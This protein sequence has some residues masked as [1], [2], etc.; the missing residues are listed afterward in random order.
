MDAAS[1]RGIDDIREIRRTRRA[2]AGRGPLQDL[3][4]R[5]G[6]LADRRR[7]E[8]AAE[9]ARGAASARR[10]RALH[11]RSGQAAEHDPLALPALRVPAARAGR[12][13]EG[14]HARVRGRGDRGARG[15]AAPDRPRGCG[16]LPRRAD[17]PRPARR[18]SATARSPSRT[19]CACSASCPSRRSSTSSTSSPRASPAS[20]CAGS[21]RW[22]R[23]GRTCPACS[24]RCSV[25]CG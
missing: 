5:R 25:T 6:A 4:P 20:C 15:R 23:A 10:V 17:D 3:H 2:A 11:D 13:R 18:S 24:T 21:T 16:L 12:A 8:R 7:L 22:P 1:H 9:D 14:A 19:P